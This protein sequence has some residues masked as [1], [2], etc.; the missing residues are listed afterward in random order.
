MHTRHEGLP[1]LC[2]EEADLRLTCWWTPHN[3]SRWRRDTLPLGL[4]GH[5]GEGTAPSAHAYC[6][7]QVHHRLHTSA[8]I[9]NHTS[10]TSA[11]YS[12]WPVDKL[13]D[14]LHPSVEL[15]Q[16]Q[17]VLLSEQT[18]PRTLPK[19]LFRPEQVKLRLKPDWGC[20]T[21]TLLVKFLLTLG[22]YAFSG[23]VLC[24]CF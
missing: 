16:S 7:T 5:E 17:D 20:V 22:F 21:E 11:H 14:D 10:P 19:I 9:P 4:A 13:L 23:F 3:R 18:Q 8:L 24:L 15:V 12:L 2:A 1:S 6:K